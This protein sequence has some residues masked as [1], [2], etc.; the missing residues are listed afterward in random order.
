MGVYVRLFYVCVSYV[1]VVALRRVDPPSQESYRLCIG[2]KTEKAANAQLKD[3]IAVGLGE[4]LKKNSMVWVRERTIPTE[5]PP[6]VGEA[7]A[8]LCG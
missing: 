3:C 6:L 7:I 5:P 8:N 2:S 4:I 1:Y